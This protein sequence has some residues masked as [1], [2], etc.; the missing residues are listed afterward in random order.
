[1]TNVL[2]DIIEKRHQQKTCQFNCL[3]NGKV[4][5]Q[6]PYQC[7]YSSND[8][9]YEN[10]LE[11]KE[12]RNFDATDDGALSTDGSKAKMS[13]FGLKLIILED[14]KDEFLLGC[15]TKEE[16]DD[17]ENTVGKL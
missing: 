5:N 4:F 17:N 13:E 2:N 9:K 10:L 1:M 15:C 8:P 6:A 3:E 16:I 14:L 11:Y 7:Q 12:V